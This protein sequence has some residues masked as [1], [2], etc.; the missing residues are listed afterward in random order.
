M[1]CGKQRWR[2]QGKERVE[3]KRC[4]QTL[5]QYITEAKIILPKKAM[6]SLWHNDRVQGPKQGR[7]VAYPAPERKLPRT[8]EVL[9]TSYPHSPKKEDEVILRGVWFALSLILTISRIHS[10]PISAALC[11]GEDRKSSENRTKHYG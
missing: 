10:H 4:G 6:I 8:P 1:L 9:F 7:V 11:R 3:S 2:G 5:P